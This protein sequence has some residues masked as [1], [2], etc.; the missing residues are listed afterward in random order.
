MQK[1]S[2]I[3]RFKNKQ[4]GIILAK[5]DKAHGTQEKKERDQNLLKNSIVFNF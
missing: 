3:K 4:T 5:S 1:N 2:E